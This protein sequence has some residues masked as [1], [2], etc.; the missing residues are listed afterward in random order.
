MVKWFDF[1]PKSGQNLRLAS[2]IR[3]F[4]HNQ[5]F[6]ITR[7]SHKIDHFS[8]FLEI[9]GD[10]WQFRTEL[11]KRSNSISTRKS[12]KIDHFSE[13]LK[14]AG[15]FWRVLAISSRT[16]KTIEF[17]PYQEIP[18]N[19]SLF[20]A[21]QNSWRFL[22]VSSRTEKR[23]N[24]IPTRKSHKIDHFLELLKIPADF[25]WFLEISNRTENINRI[26]SLPG[27]PTKLITFW[28]FSKFLAI[29]GDFEQNWNNRSNSIP[30]RKSH[31]TDHILEFLK[32]SVD[33][34]PFQAELKN[35]LLWWSGRAVRQDND[36]TILL[37][38]QWQVSVYCHT[39]II[40][41]NRFKEK[42]HIL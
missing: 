22:T 6:D 13:L 11:K 42:Y 7:K 18:Q 9:A 39:T 34:W 41:R 20:D 8:E 29:S 26:P 35:S 15:N 36:N 40:F 37:E 10:F 33:F 1:W 25:C 12:H 38:L 27:N 16:E 14:I 2:N 5:I 19:R 24:S 21:S 32:I 30:T 4:R 31:K 28:S 23:S 17:H 3:D